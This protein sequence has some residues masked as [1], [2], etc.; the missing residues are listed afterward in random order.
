MVMLNFVRGKRSFYCRLGKEASLVKFD[1][2]GHKFFMISESRIG[3]HQA[4]ISMNLYI[5]LVCLIFMF[6]IL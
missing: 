1:F 3:V 2:D 5:F 4:E 6:V